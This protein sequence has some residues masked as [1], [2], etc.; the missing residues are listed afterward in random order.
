[1]KWVQTGLKAHSRQDKHPRTFPAARK[2]LAGGK[3]S[4]VE[5]RGQEQPLVRQEGLRKGLQKGGNL[6]NTGMGGAKWGASK[7]RP[8]TISQDPGRNQGGIH[9]GDNPKA[10][11]ITGGW[12]AAV[13]REGEQRGQGRQ[14]LSWKKRGSRPSW[15]QL[16]RLC[17]WS[18]SARG[19]QC[20]QGVACS[21]HS[22]A[23][24]GSERLGDSLRV[25]PL[26][27]VPCTTLS[28]AALTACLDLPRLL[29]TLPAPLDLL[30]FV[31]RP[32]VQVLFLKFYTPCLSPC[33][34]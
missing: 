16:K 29:T 7:G 30:W 22:Q 24:R 13:G 25:C 11:G 5:G 19:I 32:D 26:L 10:I 20:I 28:S 2:G 21:W 4:G 8:W 14:W 6:W 17:Q 23:N 15:E 3:R 12:V 18:P 34:G 31:F 9:R 27:S 33:P 1:M